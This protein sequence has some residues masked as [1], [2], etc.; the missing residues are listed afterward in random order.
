[1]RDLSDFSLLLIHGFLTEPVLSNSE[2]LEVTC[3]G[4]SLKAC[5]E[6]RLGEFLLNLA[7]SCFNGVKRCNDMAR[8]NSH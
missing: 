4:F 3:S 2:V 1:V 6:D 7:P 8:L 5:S